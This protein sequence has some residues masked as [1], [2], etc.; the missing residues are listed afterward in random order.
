MNGRCTTGSR[1]VPALL[2][3][4]LL[5]ITAP[6]TDPARAFLSDAFGISDA[7]LSRVTAGQVVARTLDVSH[8]HEVATLGVVRIR[9][10]P[11]FYVSRLADIARFKRDPAVLQ[12]GTFT[13]PPAPADLAG[14]TLDDAD[15]GRLRDCRVGH[16]GVQLP[17]QAIERFRTEV[18]WRARDKQHDATRVMREVLLDYVTRYRAS[19][20]AA[21][22][23]YADTPVPFNLD[24]EFTEVLDADP[25][26]WRH[27]GGLHTHLTQYPNVSGDGGR[28]LIYWSKERVNGRPV[29]S[30]T[31][32][33]IVPMRDE[34]PA[35]FAIASKQIYAMHY[36]DASLGVTVLVRDRSAPLPATY[37]VYLN[38]SR[39]DVF[40]GVFGGLA[41]RIVSGK[42]R[43]LVSDQLARLQQTL[44]GQFERRDDHDPLRH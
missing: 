40:D 19:G 28:D 33:A 25:R 20:P 18:N 34:S 14:L 17:A 21:A 13:D 37:V 15:V 5:V 7:D 24:R 16:C 2:V 23:E 32:L 38:R 43:S 8:P 3:S 31:H 9:I 42:A 29:V 27:A 26:T 11:D 4:T 12:I 44:E 22:L 1:L 35:E 41:R 39:I 36:F 30:V 6:A 10:T